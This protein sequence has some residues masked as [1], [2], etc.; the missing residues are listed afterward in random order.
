MDSDTEPRLDDTKETGTS[1]TESSGENTEEKSVNTDADIQTTEKPVENAESSI[2]KKRNHKMI[3]ILAVLLVLIGL[4]G[5]FIPKLISN[6]SEKVV[7]A[8]T[9]STPKTTTVPE[10][11]YATEALK[12]FA[13]PTTGEVWYDTPKPMAKQGWLKSELA[14]SYSDITDGTATTTVAQQM[15]QNAPTYKEVGTRGTSR[16]VLV[17]SQPDMGQFLELFE[18]H[19]DGKVYAI[20]EPNRNGKL[21]DGAQEQL[22]GATTNKVSVID[23]ETHYD[24]LSIPETLPLANGETVS[25]PEYT[26]IM[27][28][29]YNPGGETPHQFDP[30][31]FGS[32]TLY[33]TEKTYADTGL[34][35]I[36]Y[37]V[38]LPFGTT[39]TMD[40]TPNTLSLEKY[41]FTNNAPLQYA[42]RYN[43]KQ[44][45]DTLNPIARGCGGATEAVTR[46]DKLKDADLIPVGKTDTGRTVYGLKSSDAALITK[47]YDEYKQMFE[48]TTDKLDSLETFFAN[49]GVVIIKNAANENLVYVRTQYA[50]IG[51]CAKPVVYLYPTTSTVVSVRVGASV[52]VSDPFYEK[53]GWQNV[54]ADPSGALSYRGQ[55][56]GSL[57]WEGQGYGSYPAITSGTVVKRA[58][59]AKTMRTQLAAQGLNAQE[60][61]DFMAF[62]EPKVP[63][64]P[65][66]R[67]TWL[68]TAQMNELAPLMVTPKPQTVIRVFLDMDGYDVA[69]NLPKQTL[70]KTPRQGFTVVEWGGLTAGKSVK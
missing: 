11:S 12:R 42:D 20:F 43:G 44:T 32:S 36:G 28:G 7:T 30:Q 24:S 8:S 46:S 69:P 13:E 35:N 34:T 55:T 17:Y 16:I 21:Y 51:G 33:R 53:N 29:I 26:T 22:D 25:A 1:G 18:V 49:H 3:V 38:G 45:I 56:Y 4:A 39:V 54:L 10:K 65:Y 15:A 27:S 58:D 5:F 41:T 57:F 50:L 6:K 14:S 61:K 70:T 64:K 67:L 52:T 19:A 40:Y 68:T 9:T 60:T 66:V 62:W 59:A 48:N 31:K 23:V 2:P 63:N 47:A 37:Q